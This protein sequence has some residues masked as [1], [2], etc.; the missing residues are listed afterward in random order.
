MARFVL[1]GP[2]FHSYNEM[3]AGALRRLGHHVDVLNMP[4][5]DEGIPTKLRLLYYDRIASDAV[6][7]E[8]LSP[9]SEAPVEEMR[10]QFMS[11]RIHEYNRELLKRVRSQRPE[12]VLVVKGHLVHP[13]TVKAMSEAGAAVVMWCYDSAVR[14][15][16]VLAAGEHYDQFYTF[17]PSD[18]EPLRERGIDAKFL[19]DAYDEQTYQ[20]L[21]ESET[22]R[23]MCFVGRLWPKR[24]RVFNDV[25]ERH[26][27]K[28]FTIWGRQW[29]SYNP[30]LLYEYKIQNRTLQSTVVNRDIPPQR[31]NEIYNE[32]RICLNVHQQ[33]SRKGFN[34]RTLEILG[35]SGFQLVE[36]KPA[37][38]REFEVG[39]E[40][41]CYTDTDDLA[42]KIDYYL[43][44][45]EE[46]RR[47]AERGR[48][49]VLE[50][51]TF[52]DRMQTILDDLGNI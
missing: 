5:P 21:D 32:S 10:Y 41:A 49:A 36:R 3:M 33:Q 9:A 12:V 52:E 26:P 6:E 15:R 34:N 11:D 46:R 43:E 35:A 48:A 7:Y 31:V 39:E 4:E 17:E 8:F 1:T 29:N 19:P 51:H 42:E 25:L 14:F 44:H 27:E 30:F 45:D 16:K 38:E 50:R 23:D 28:S 24:K 2:D 18:I 20:P 22:K 40:I 47:F 13:E 37:I